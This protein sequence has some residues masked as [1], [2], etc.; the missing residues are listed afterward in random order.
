MSDRSIAALAAHVEDFREYGHTVA[1]AHGCFDLL[2]P[3]HL[4]HLRQA[5][6]QADLLVVTITPDR[7]VR[8]GPDRP[9]FAQDYRCEMLEA[10]SI[11]NKVAIADE[12]GAVETIMRIK[13][14][15]FVKGDEYRVQA[16]DPISDIAMERAAI[17]AV[18]GRLHF[19]S[20]QTFS[21]TQLINRH[22][23]F[24]APGLNAYVAEARAKGYLDILPALLDKLASLKVL[25]IGETIIDEYRYVTPMGK[26]PKESV[27]AVRSEESE[28]F[29]GGVAASAAHLANFCP[30]TVIT[31]PP[32]WE[33]RKS[34]F[35]EQGFN[36]KLFEV[37]DER[38]PMTFDDAGLAR[39]IEEQADQYDLIIV[40]DFGHGF[41]TAA[42]RSAIMHCSVPVAIN[43][44]SNSANHGFNPV[45]KYPQA[46]YVCIDAPEA[47]LAVGD[48]DA[49]IADI[50]GRLL[51]AKMTVPKV[52][53][54]MG[55]DG[56]IV[57]SREHGVKR[58]PAFA[59][60]IVDTMGAGDAYL[61]I[62]APLTLLTEDM[63]AVGFVGNIVGA[64]KVGRVG[65]REP[66]QKAEVLAYI[67]YLLK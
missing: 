15:V 2:H 22:I 55:K 47:R 39:S 14:N 30:V 13:P 35:I 32:Q 50:A 52:A 29:H 64:L 12:A 51:H 63:E 19:T 42:I 54:T 45:S 58:I 6:M 24:D 59:T 62:T 49:S 1:L 3:G 40:N 10:L 11:V 57:Y 16:E 46:D 44:Q 56:S 33:I 66:I 9:L 53:V 8:K 27:L 31:Q 65:H 28:Q 23:G 61:A 20:G 36:R 41:M 67:K 17:E 7:Y 4:E 18:G 60:K 48:Q 38:A 25:L 26:P 21:S 37:F 43:A 5:A 34:R